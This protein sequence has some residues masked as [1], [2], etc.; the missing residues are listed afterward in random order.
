MWSTFL[1][2][3]RINLREKSSL[4]W[5]FCFPILLSTMFLGMFGNLGATYEI[6]TM[7]FAVVANDDYCKAEGAQ[8]LIAAMQRTP[9]APQAC[10]TAPATMD[11]DAGDTDLRDLLDVTAVD[12]VGDA[13]D[14]INDDHDVRGFLTVDG[15]G[16]V[17]MTISRATVSNAN[18]AM[19]SPGLPISLSIL[20]GA[21]GMFNRQTLTVAQIMGA[22]PAVLH[23]ADFTA[24]VQET[25]D[26][27][28]QVRLTNFKPDESARYYYA[29]LAMTA[30]MAM[31]F[32]VTTVCATQ[33]NLSALGMRRSMAPL[34]RLRQLMGGFL[35]SWLCTFCSLLVAL[36]Y[37]H[38]VCRISFGGRWAATMLAI[39]VASFASN[40][41]GTLLGSLPKLTAGTKIGL[42]TAISCV[43]SL[44]SGLYGSGAM[45]LSDW[46]QRNAPIVAMINPTQ[47]VTNLFYDILYYDS[48]TPFFRTVGILLTMAVL[49]LALATVFLRRQRYAH[50]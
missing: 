29:L 39:V 35:A 10:G 4:F 31:S 11:V 50:L 22:D 19:G 37:I 24:A 45:A 14:L 17:H 40:A 5:L 27:T 44:L 16:M 18:D 20:N 25:P 47:Q 46:I 48:Y 41:L 49:A 34:T 43:L 9:V 1:T 2:T 32:A 23:D 6:T 12:T 33:A 3:L 30:L 7:R 36:L 15:D 42:T 21:I 13:S 8:Q 38:F 26:F 28:H